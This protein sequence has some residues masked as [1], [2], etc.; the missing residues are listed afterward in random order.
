MLAATVKGCLMMSNERT[1]FFGYR[2]NERPYEQQQPKPRLNED[3]LKAGQLQIERKTFYFTL[4]ENPRGRFLRISE[5][6]A[7]HRNSIMIPSTGLDEFRKMLE[8][9]VNASNQKPPAAP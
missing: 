3:T 5:E 9:M 7:G 8:D 6:A 1:S 2:L 4:K